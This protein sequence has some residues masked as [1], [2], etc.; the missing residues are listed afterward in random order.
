MTEPVGRGATDTILLR[1]L[2][3]LDAMRAAK[4]DGSRRAA[5][6]ERVMPTRQ[7]AAPAV[8]EPG[9]SFPRGSFVDLRV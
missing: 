3:G 9:R 5:A 8:G 7:P 4:P 2:Q 6:D 1:A